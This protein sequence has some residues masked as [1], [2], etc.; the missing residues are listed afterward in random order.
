MKAEAE[1]FHLN[2][3]SKSPGTLLFDNPK[4]NQFKT[5]G[6][7][8]H[9]P[10]DKEAKIAKTEPLIFAVISEVN[11]CWQT[12]DGLCENESKKGQIRNKV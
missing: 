4:S 5:D 8:L 10:S 9:F 12:A 11:S 6:F 7:F 2:L 3:R 1:L